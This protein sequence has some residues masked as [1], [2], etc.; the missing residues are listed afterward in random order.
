M[1]LADDPP[2]SPERDGGPFRLWFD[3]SPVPLLVRDIGTDRHF[4]NKAFVDLCGYS[5]EVISSRRIEDYLLSPDDRDTYVALYGELLSGMRDAFTISG[6]VHRADGK[7]RRVLVRVRAAREPLGT[8]RYVMAAFE[9]VTELAEASAALEN[10]RNAL[11]TLLDAIPDLIHFTDTEGRILRANRAKAEQLGAMSPNEVIGR[12]IADFEPGGDATLSAEEGRVVLPLT[13]PV[14]NLEHPLR[15]PFPDGEMRRF[16][17]SRTP[18]TREGRTYGYVSISRDISEWNLTKELLRASNETLRAL[19]DAVPNAIVALDRQNRVT[20]WN[21]GAE[22]LFGWTAEETLNQPC[23]VPP[24]AHQDD[25]PFLF[26]ALQNEGV[27][28]HVE[29]PCPTKDGRTL[30]VDCSVGALYDSENQFTGAI[31][32]YSDI[33]HRKQIEARLTETN[34]TLEAVFGASPLPIITLDREF[35]V[36]VWN[37]AAERTFGWSAEEVIGGPNPIIPPELLEERDSLN[38]RILAGEEVLRMETYRRRKDG[39]TLPVN[40]YRSAL[41]DSQGNVIGILGI[42]E[43]IS[44]RKRYEEALADSERLF[45]TIFEASPIGIALIN[46]EGAF[47]RANRA[48]EAIVGYSEAELQSATHDWTHPDDA[49]PGRSLWNELVAGARDTFRV[50]ERVFTKNGVTKF[51]SRT[52]A[53]VRNNAGE[54][55]YSIHLVRDITARKQQEAMLLKLSRAVEEAAD[56]LFITDRDGVIEYVNPAFENLTGY[57]ASEVIGKTPRILKSGKHDLAFYERLWKTLLDGETFRAVFI[58]RKKNGDLYYE[59]KAISPIFDKSGNITHFVSTGR[60][61]THELQMREALRESEERFRLLVESTE[62]IVFTLDT[63]MRMVAAYGRGLERLG[64]RRE[65]FVGKTA[66]EAYGPE[67]GQIHMAAAERAFMGESVFYEWSSPT[68]NGLRHFQTALSPMRRDHRITALVGV[69][70]DITSLKVAE[71]SL[72]ELNAQ[73]E[74]RVRERT[75]ELDEANARLARSNEELTH[76]AYVVSHDLR[77]PLRTVTSFAELLQRRYGEHLDATAQEFIGYI[78][79][80]AAR[81]QRMIQA[82]LEYSRLETRTGKAEPVDAN[83]IL[84]TVRRDLSERLRETGGEI[85]TDPLPMV[86]V[87]PVQFYQL[88]LNLVGNA[89]KFHGDQPPRVWVTGERTPDGMCRFAVRDNGIGIPDAMRE[90]I[91]LMFRRLHREGEYEGVGIGLAVCRKIVERHGGR[92]WVESRLGEGSTF[93]FTLPSA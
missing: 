45:R 40:L 91:F 86:L 37:P 2:C 22:Y 55:L 83:A 17:T 52:V 11:Q 87:E 38:R 19:L 27:V 13:E 6:Q 54:F 72:R 82:I 25:Y 41:R 30:Y 5:L 88:L 57:T 48:L 90:Q 68:P 67:V 78:V 70:R 75:R 32:V 1:E 34:A 59:E 31:V 79:S 3:E 29:I 33:T 10:E 76:F 51:T 44:E 66:L 24:Y 46:R 64:Y 50:E 18:L 81:M 84:D 65:D 12:R 42:I 80:G 58:N 71:A 56:S 73:L 15:V 77:E 89:V 62:D 93:Y 28:R 49:E 9:D 61:V 26:E 4:A 8:L 92:I 47:L 7:Q 60:D 39:S 21:P 20:L 43:D 53:A 36:T 16:L 74:E 85:L 63:N 14:F 69:M 23:P 35:H